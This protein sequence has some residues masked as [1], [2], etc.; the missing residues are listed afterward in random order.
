M[1]NDLFNAVRQ[2]L[3][4]KKIEQDPA[5]LGYAPRDLQPKLSPADI[6]DK[7]QLENP[8]VKLL[9]MTEPE[10]DEAIIGVIEHY[11]EYAGKKVKAVQYDQ[12]KVLE[13]NVNKMG[14]TEDEAVEYFEYNQ[15]GAYVGE[16]TPQFKFPDYGEE[17]WYLRLTS[18]HSSVI[19]LE[20]MEEEMSDQFFTQTQ[21]S[22]CPND[23]KTRTMSWF[24]DE[25]IC[26][27]CSAKESDIKS[28]LRF[29]GMKDAKEGCGYVPKIEEC[30]HCNGYGS[31][32]KEE[33]DKCTKCNG[34]GLILEKK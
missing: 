25:A 5:A 21:C 32:L 12:A 31:S 4:A 6:R 2:E 13:I 23:L 16:Q 10:F 26:M 27:E 18:H 3:W 17:Y 24:T 1:K 29:L 28:K 7:L 30:D 22:R 8:E 19:L 14:M 9:F 20:T 33:A 11:D 15:A 34:T